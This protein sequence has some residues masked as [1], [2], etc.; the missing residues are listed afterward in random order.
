MDMKI[1]RGGG[2]LRIMGLALGVGITCMTI[3]GCEGPA[4]GGDP[5]TAPSGTDGVTQVS[6]AATF[7]G[8][9]ICSAVLPGNWRDTLSIP[10]AWTAAN[11]SAWAATTGVRD[12]QI[13]CLF[14]PA[15][16]IPAY[17]WGGL[18]SIGSPV[19]LPEPNCGWN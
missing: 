18:T 7:A 8:T 11:C 16:G 17:S 1:S 19:A 9:K 14:S 10:A 15:A 4:D 6:G 5:A 13:G 3:A 12:Y 2:F